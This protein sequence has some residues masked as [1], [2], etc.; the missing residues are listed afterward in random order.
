MT[1]VKL[2]ICRIDNYPETIGYLSQAVVFSSR[3]APASG[4]MAWGA[5]NRALATARDDT[6]T[7]YLP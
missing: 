4:P 5:F 6:H 2:F 7:F 3:P 1:S